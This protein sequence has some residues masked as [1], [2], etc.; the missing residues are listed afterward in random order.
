M[1]EKPGL[2]ECIKT[3]LGEAGLDPS[4]ANYEFCYRYLTGA[5]HQL[6][7]AVDAVRGAGR[8]NARAVAN[9]RREL[10]GT[11]AAGLSQLLEDAERHLTRMTGYVEQSDADARS[12]RDR[13]GRSDLDGDLTLERQR[14]M[15]AEMIDATNTMIAQT[16]LL[17]KEL[18]QSTRE[19]DVLKADLE[20]ARVDARS[21][22]LTGLANRKACCDYLDAQIARARHD[23]RPL[24]LIFLDIDHFKKFNDNFGHRMGDEVLR[25]VAQR[26]EKA[27]HGAGFVARW[28]GEEF[29]AVLPGFNAEEAF[30]YAERLRVDM[31]SRTVR[32][33]ATGR[34]VGR[35]TLSLGVAD[36]VPQDSAQTLVDRADQALYDAKAEGRDRVVRWQEAA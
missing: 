30:G 7:E 15:L 6:I 2:F 26:L 22:A 10:Y 27:F 20:I 8:L 36:L 29:V 14:A 31:A 33:R 5:D 24:S 3:L 16:E 23:G 25:L 32:A 28:G 11:G 19:I 4:P 12:Y 34:E 9:I 21:D 13:L 17:Q 1:S 35:I 18:V